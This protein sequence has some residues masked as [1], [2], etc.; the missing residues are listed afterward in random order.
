VKVSIVVPAFNEERELAGALRSMRAAAAA[1]ERRGWTT[2]LI[3]CDNNSTDRT[4]DIAREAGAIVVFEPVNQIS[5][6]RNAGAARATGDWLVFI[7]ADSHPGP[8][9]F[10]DV[11]AAM[12][13]GRVL[14]GG[15]RV[16]FESTHVGIR[17]A[18]AFWYALSRAFW[19]AAGSFVFCRRDAFRELGG[20][21]LELYA[22]EEID[23][24]R[25]LKRLARAR[26]QRLVILTRH[27]L[28]TSARKA[29]LYTWS[30]V[31][32]LMAKTVVTGG[33][34]LRSAK[35]S[36]AWYDGRR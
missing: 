35:D 11:A 5:R 7:D 4:A 24:S 16:V 17:A 23:F 32:R 25:R 10:E 15:C 14:G 6:A 3:V 20:F 12:E 1:W 18:A 8:A 33:R 29:K 34:T 26:G 13:S 22:T 27:P 31:L 36:F 21:S 30:E 2:E 28:V 9:L 19:W